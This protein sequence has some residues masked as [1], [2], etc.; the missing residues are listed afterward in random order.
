MRHVVAPG[1]PAERGDTGLFLDERLVGFAVF[2]RCAL[3]GAV[4]YGLFNES[5]AFRID[6]GGRYRVDVY[7]VGTEFLRQGLVNRMMAALDAQ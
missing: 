6:R 7:A 3:D 5:Q 2:P 4:G 1:H